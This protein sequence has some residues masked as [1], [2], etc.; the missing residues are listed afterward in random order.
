MLVASEG[1]AWALAMAIEF[2]F[3][4]TFEFDFVAA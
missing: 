4:A 2:E 1:T 3:V